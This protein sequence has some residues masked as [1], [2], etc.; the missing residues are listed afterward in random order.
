MANGKKYIWSAET[1]PSIIE[2]LHTFEFFIIDKNDNKNKLRTE[3]YVYF[4]SE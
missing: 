2:N 4:Q 3:Y 1:T